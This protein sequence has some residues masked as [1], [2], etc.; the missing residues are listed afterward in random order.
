MRDPLRGAR[1][2]L[3]ALHERLRDSRQDDLFDAAGATA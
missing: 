2:E 1:A 3:Q